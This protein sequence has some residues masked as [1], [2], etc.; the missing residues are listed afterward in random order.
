MRFVA[1]LRVSTK[2]QQD[3]YGFDVQRDAVERWAKTNGHR[4]VRWTQDVYTG[5]NDGDGE[6]VGRT[7]LADALEALNADE[8]DGVVFPRLDRLAR[9]LIVQETVI[10]QILAMDKVAAS[11]VP[12]E[13]DQL[14]DDPT[15]VLVRQILG[16]VAQY[17]RAMIVLRL[18]AGR[19]R[20]AEDGGYA[21]GSPR[22]GYRSEKRTRGSRVESVLV[23]DPAQQ[24]TIARM[25]ELRAE[26]LSLRQVAATLNEE[27][28]PAKRGGTWHPRT[29][30]TA[31]GEYRNR[32]YP[33][34]P[35]KAS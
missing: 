15:R 13:N 30:A 19:R 11:T 31:L 24:D 27:Q 20:K 1:H 17:D 12:A 33:I 35:A 22:F 28:R 29:V 3:G 8:A 34:P 21:Y 7:G 25:R 10:E 6:L 14:N 2:G 16:A 26:G 4:I 9:A 32:S 23:E 5:K 18:Q